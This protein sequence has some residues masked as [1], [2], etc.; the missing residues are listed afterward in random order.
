MVAR[1]S[2]RLRFRSFSVPPMGLSRAALLGTLQRGQGPKTEFGSR[3][4]GSRYSID[5]LLRRLIARGSFVDRNMAV[6]VDQDTGLLILAVHLALVQAANGLAP[7]NAAPRAMIDG[8]SAGY[9][10]RFGAQ[11]ITPI[12]V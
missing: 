9:G 4:A 5:D 1:L 11:D 3:K 10:S 2:L 7:R 8:E 12:L 6:G